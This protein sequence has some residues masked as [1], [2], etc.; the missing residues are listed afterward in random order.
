MI[1][2][3]IR[4]KDFKIDKIPLEEAF[5]LSRKLGPLIPALAPLYMAGLRGEI[6]Q[7]IS[8]GDVHA[9]ALA[10]EPFAQ[11]LGDMKD[12]VANYI[13]Y[14]S[15]SVVKIKQGTVFSNITSGN[16]LMFNNLELVDL[17]QLAFLSIRET[18]GN[19]MPGLVTQG[20]QEEPAQ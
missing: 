19:F 11:V 5:H 18:L 12:E 14:T 1:E 6:D 3:H 17:Y 2:V 9:A 13:L 7:A 15:L 16:S 20:A 4:G 8:G 10:A